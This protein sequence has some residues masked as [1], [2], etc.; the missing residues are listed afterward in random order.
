VTEEIGKKS[1]KFL[2][3]KNKNENITLQNLWE[4]AK[5]KFYSYKCLH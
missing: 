2:E 5:G 4:T 3:S 1:K